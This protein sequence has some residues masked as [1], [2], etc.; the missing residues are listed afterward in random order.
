[1]KLKTSIMLKVSEVFCLKTT[2][3]IVCGSLY[4]LLGQSSTFDIYIDFPHIKVNC[5]I[6]AANIAMLGSQ[7]FENP[8]S[9]IS[10]SHGAGSVQ[11]LGGLRSYITG[12]S[13]S[14]LAIILVSDVFGKQSIFHFLSL[15]LSFCTYLLCWL[16]CLQLFLS[17]D[18]VMFFLHKNF[19][20]H[21]Q[22][23]IFIFKHVSIDINILLHLNLT[24]TQFLT[25]VSLMLV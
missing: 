5:T 3:Y 20:S 25:E 4:T 23:I 12:P 19:A 21:I 24:F 1:M 17:V 22:H 16:C 6:C 10:G 9:L 18:P 8:P 11:E 15:I 14:K 2:I 7:C 13:D